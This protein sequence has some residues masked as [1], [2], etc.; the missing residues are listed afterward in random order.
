MKTKAPAVSHLGAIVV[1]LLAAALRLGGF[2]ETLVGGDQSTI[3][4]AAAD[5][6]ALRGFPLIGMKSSTGVMQ[7]ATS[8]YLSALALALVHK[9][10]AIKWFFSILD[11][12]ALA[13]LYRTV[14]RVYGH[15]AALIASLLYASNPWI[16]E[17]NRW[18]WY[19][20]LLPTF[21][22]VAFAALLALLTASR[23]AQGTLTLAVVA[24]TLLGTVHVGGCRGQPFSSSSA[25][26]SPG[27]VTC[28]AASSG[29]ADS[30]GRSRRRTSST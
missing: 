16:V 12:L 1:L 27:T 18:I 14:D 6:V 23:P 7:T 24:A 11:L 17:Y 5:L 19:Q 9:V 13:Y 26:S 4:E 30:P 3:L 10:A 2:Q 25:R 8:I 29:G 28:G 21:S 22:T 15:R 20:T